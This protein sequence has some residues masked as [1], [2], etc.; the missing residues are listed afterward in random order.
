MF[1]SQVPVYHLPAYHLPVCRLPIYPFARCSKR[2][3]T[4]WRSR[5]SASRASRR[6]YS[7]TRLPAAAAAQVLDVRLKSEFAAAMSSRLPV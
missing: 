5:S 2:A 1:I 7:F 4:T 6:I 3:R